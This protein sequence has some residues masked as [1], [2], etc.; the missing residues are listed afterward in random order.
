MKLR[1]GY[2]PSFI[3]TF[4]KLSPVLQSDML[5]AIKIFQKNS[6]DPILRTHKLQGKF[7]RCSS[8]SVNYKYR[9]VFTYIDKHTVVFLGVG[10]HDVYR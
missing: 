7:K 10:D 3:R 1:V 8:F 9:I 5:A 4:A 6:R 2:K